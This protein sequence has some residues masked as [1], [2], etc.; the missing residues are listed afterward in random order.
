MDRQGL[1]L[2]LDEIDP[3]G[4][5]ARRFAERHGAEGLELL[6]VNG[7]EIGRLPRFAGR[8]MDIFHAASA[9]VSSRV[10]AA[11]PRRARD[12]A[13]PHPV[14]RDADVVQPLR[15]AGRRHQRPAIVGGA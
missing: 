7:C 1:A 15:R 9:W 10:K 3:G 13:A 8:P 2:D 12:A 5:E 4:A 11:K 6:A 14:A